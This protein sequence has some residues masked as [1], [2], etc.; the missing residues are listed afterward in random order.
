MKISALGECAE[1][2]QG[3]SPTA[4]NVL[5]YSLPLLL[6]GQKFKK[7]L[8]MFCPNKEGLNRPKYHLTLLSLQTVEQA[9]LLYILSAKTFFSV[10]SP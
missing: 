8:D 4:P 2:I 7:P 1:W 10:G 5:N 6:M 3:H 9:A